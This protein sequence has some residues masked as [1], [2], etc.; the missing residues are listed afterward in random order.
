MTDMIKS[1]YALEQEAEQIA[2]CIFDE[3]KGDEDAMRDA[4][5]EYV[6]QSQHVIYTARAIA[7]CGSCDTDAGEEW[8]ADVYDKPF[9]GC[10]T[11]A[12]VCMRLACATLLVATETALQDLI[13]A[14]EDE[15]EDAAN[16]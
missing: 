15:D 4:V 8:L 6:D 7:I 12:E 1:D 11:F 3:H 14:D 5:S 16:A 9:D 13:D 10:A 2:R